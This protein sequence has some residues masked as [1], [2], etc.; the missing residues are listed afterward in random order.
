MAKKNPMPEG[1]PGKS[2][3]EAAGVK[4]VEELRGKSE[5]ELQEF[6][7]VGPA[8]AAEIIAWFESDGSTDGQSESAGLTQQDASGRLVKDKT[9]HT[10]RFS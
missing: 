9:G 3:L 8:T 5:A 2:A 6:D 1:F 4:S 7:G 10:L